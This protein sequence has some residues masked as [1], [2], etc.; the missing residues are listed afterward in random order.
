MEVRQH[1]LGG[2]TF[3]GL[4]SGGL[5]FGDHFEVSIKTS[6]FIVIYR[7]YS[8]NKRQT[9]R[10]IWIEINY[11][12]PIFLWVLKWSISIPLRFDDCFV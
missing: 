4:Y 12:F 11:V 1:F 3:G 7:Y 9:K 2:L 8:E 6:K 10:Q 5:I